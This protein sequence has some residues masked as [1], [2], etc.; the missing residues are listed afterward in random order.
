[1][2]EKIDLTLSMPRDEYERELVRY[3]TALD[4]LGRQVWLRKRPVVIVYEGWDAAG[5]GGNI[6][7]LTSQLDP[8]G[9]VVHPIAAPKGDDA[10]HHYLWRFWRRLPEKGQIAIF[11]RS[12]YGRVMVE[13]V[14]G[15]CTEEQWRRAYREINDFER[16]LVE[17]GTILCKFWIHIGRDEQLRR[18]EERGDDKLKSW[19]LT[20][21][22]WRNR[23]K[24]DLYE[25]AVEDMLVKTSTL[26]APWTI[27]EGNCKWY[28]RIKTL[29]TLVDRLSEELDSDPFRENPLLKA[30]R[31]GGK[32]RRDEARP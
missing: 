12:W 31:N 15:F 32:R 29:R 28:A 8:R 23:E 30:T 21:E 10:T 18:F 7:R 2:L 3:Q 16:Q 1:M 22:D 25:R 14:E 17:F 26:V 27:V 6:K 19:K 4:L 20:A 9:Y 11:D 5:K 24:W 13:R